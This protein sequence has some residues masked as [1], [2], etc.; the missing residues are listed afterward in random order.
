MEF[1]FEVD[2]NCLWFF[3]WRLYSVREFSKFYGKAEKKSTE[4]KYS[5]KSTNIQMSVENY[6]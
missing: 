6:F 2:I 1:K 4:L 3:L 5:I